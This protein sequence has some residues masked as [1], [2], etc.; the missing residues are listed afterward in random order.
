MTQLNAIMFVRRLWSIC[1]TTTG[2]NSR[3]GFAHYDGRWFAWLRINWFWWP[4]FLWTKK[5]KNHKKMHFHMIASL[6]GVINNR[7]VSKTYDWICHVRC[8]LECQLIGI[9]KWFLQFES[10]VCNGTMVLS[11]LNV[12]LSICSEFRIS[13]WIVRNCIYVPEFAGKKR[14]RIEKNIEFS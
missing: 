2:S 10:E 11:V 9:N 5:L 13:I 4:F 1:W 3:Y 6:F 8:D 14:E 12:L 7:K